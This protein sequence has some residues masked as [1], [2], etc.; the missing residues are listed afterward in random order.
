[1]RASARKHLD[2]R[3][4]RLRPTD[5]WARPPRGWIRAIRDALGM[6]AEQL[7]KRLHVSQP[8]ISILERAEVEDSITLAT[9]RRAAEALDCTLIYALVPRQPLEATLMERART[10]A[11]ETISR[12]DQTMQLENQSVSANSLNNERERLARELM[13]RPRQLWDR[14]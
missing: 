13:D 14:Q 10:V 1:M 7:A 12:I 4:D 8:R 3:L 11:D 2:K 6:T 9:L 5:E